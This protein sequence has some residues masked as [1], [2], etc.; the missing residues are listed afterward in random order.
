[1]EINNLIAI[2]TKVKQLIYEK[3]GLEEKQLVPGILFVDDL[4]IDSL[5]LFELIIEIEN[6][7]EINIP[8]EEAEKLKSPDA[9]IEYIYKQKIK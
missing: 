9:L 4:R 3:L 8:E 7:F 6:V 5:D 1:M 2:E